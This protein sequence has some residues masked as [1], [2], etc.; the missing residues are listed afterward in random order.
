MNGLEVQYWSLDIPNPLEISGKKLGAEIH[1]RA[2]DP[3]KD[4]EVKRGTGIYEIV[5]YTDKD[6]DEKDAMIVKDF[7]R[8]GFKN[9]KAE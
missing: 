1:L 3:S 8:I 6:V 9:V 7:V 2:A 5:L 4:G